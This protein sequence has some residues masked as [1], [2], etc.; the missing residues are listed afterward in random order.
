MVNLPPRL[1]SIRIQ[2]EMRH[3][4]ASRRVPPLPLFPA[5]HVVDLHDDDQSF[6]EAKDEQDASALIAAAGLP[7][8]PPSP[9]IPST[10]TSTS[11][12]TTR[13]ASVK[14]FFKSMRFG[15]ARHVTGTVQEVG[16]EGVDG[17]TGASAGAPLVQLLSQGEQTAA[18]GA[19]VSRYAHSESNHVE[20]TRTSRGIGQPAVATGDETP[21]G[22]SPVSTVI[23]ER[24]SIST[25][26]HITTP[27]ASPLAQ[28]PP[29]LSIRQPHAGAAGSGRSAGSRDSHSIT[30]THSTGASHWRKLRLRSM[31]AASMVATHTV[32]TAQGTRKILTVQELEQMP[33]ADLPAQLTAAR[34]LFLP[35]SPF[36]H[37]WDMLIVLLL[38]YTAVML[39]LRI[40]FLVDDDG[41]HLDVFEVVVDVFF[42]IDVL[43]TFNTAIEMA[44]GTVLLTH[45]LIA[46]H[47][48]FSFFLTDVLGSL[49]LYLL[50]DRGGLLFRTTRLLRL[51]RLVRVLRLVRLL[52]ASRFLRI[53]NSVRQATRYVQALP[54]PTS[55]SGS[56]HLT[57]LSVGCSCCC[58]VMHCTHTQTCGHQ[59]HNTCDT[60]DYPFTGHSCV[61]VQTH[62]LLF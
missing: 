22:G 14:G 24:P 37:R 28:P 12:H 56:R 59:L 6:D 50:V 30:G 16:A 27:H 11:K 8:I 7:P 31:V 38:M 53:S 5:V 60:A 39:P 54:G 51:P 32:A 10:N 40:A 9:T 4:N 2:T 19:S 48:L 52:K 1:V 57:L 26:I 35:H 49:P 62:P 21:V 18:N 45:A 46:R 23:T 33:A 34:W 61:A 15:S 20:H 42:M 44:N 47:Y 17:S 41:G 3:N 29:V 25:P 58:R 13:A 36:K 43:L 55:C